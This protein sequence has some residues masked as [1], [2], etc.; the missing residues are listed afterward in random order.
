MRLSISEYQH[1]FLDISDC[2]KVISFVSDKE[3]CGFEFLSPQDFSDG[4]QN[5]EEKDEEKA[6]AQ[7]KQ[8]LELAE[9]E[10]GLLRAQLEFTF[11][12]SVSSF[13]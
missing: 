5:L 13:S 3:V 4:V 6:K 9:Q 11:C 12:S 2:S 10:I 7:R 1:T 8:K